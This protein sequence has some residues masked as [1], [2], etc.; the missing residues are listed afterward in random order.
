MEFTVSHFEDSD[1]EFDVVFESKEGRLIGEAEGKDNKAVNIDK[2]R[3][4]EMNMHED[5]AREDIEQMAKGALIGN[6]YRLSEPK[7][8]GDFFTTKCLTAASRSGTALISTVDLFYVAK[9]LSEKGDKTFSRKCRQ[10][11]IKTTGVIKFPDIPLSEKENKT[12]IDVQN[13]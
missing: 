9:Y 2:L 1:S 11:I 6:A 4:L 7:E 12:I 5:F 8:R 3:Q 10:A 13:T